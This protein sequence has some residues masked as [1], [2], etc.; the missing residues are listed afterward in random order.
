MAADVAVD[1]ANNVFVVDRGNDRVQ[2]FD[3]N[4][5]FITKWESTGSGDGQFESPIGITV[6]SKGIVYVVD[7]GNSRVQYFSIA[8]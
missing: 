1:K 6:D 7:G 2:K 8:K 5:N 4:G 3:S